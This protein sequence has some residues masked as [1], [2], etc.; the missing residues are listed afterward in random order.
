M[1]KTDSKIV[2]HRPMKINSQFK[3]FLPI[4]EEQRFGLEQQILTDKKIIHPLIIGKYPENGGFA[5]FLIDGHCRY[6]IAKKHNLSFEETILNFNN[7]QE[8]YSWIFNQQKNKRNW[9]DWQEYEAGQKLKEKLLEL[10]RQQNKEF[11]GRPSHKKPLS[12]NDKGFIPHDTRE[13]IAKELGWSTGKVAQAD[14]ISKKADK[15]TLTKLRKGETTISQ[16]YKKV[17]VTEKETERKKESEKSKN[18]K[19]TDKRID[20]R[21]GDFK[22]VLADIPDNSIDLILTD[23]PYPYA[24]I[25]CWSDLSLFASKKLSDGGFC[26]AYSGQLFLPE[27]MKRLSEHLNYYW[28]CGLKHEGKIGQRFEVNFF[29]RMKPILIYQKGKKIKQKKWGEDLFAFDS[30]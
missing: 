11:G 23:P 25:K 7:I 12:I 5:E 4:A 9:N 28:L 14:V 16:A 6:E 15:E 8:V 2:S 24:H 1:S 27:V 17:K 30:V 21:Y 13:V 18:I 3:D 22:K 19:I 10:G 20:F 26:I 29:N